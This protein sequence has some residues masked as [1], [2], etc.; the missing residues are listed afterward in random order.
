MLK[1]HQ[2]DLVSENVTL[3]STLVRGWDVAA[4]AGLA[5]LT[6]AVTSHEAQFWH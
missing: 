2:Y 3:N 4:Y 6:V 5:I 1:C